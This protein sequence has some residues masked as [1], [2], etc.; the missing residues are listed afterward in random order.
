MF[1]K[2]IKNIKKSFVRKPEEKFKYNLQEVTKLYRLATIDTKTNLF[3]SRYFETQMK[4]EVAIAKRYNRA[5]SLIL[6][7]IDDFKKIN[8]KYGY[9]MGDEILKRVSLILKNNVRDTDIAARFGGEEFTILLPE[10]E[11]DKAKELAER[12]RTIILNDPFLKSYGLTVS[13]GISCEETKRKKQENITKKL[14]SKF[15]PVNTTSLDFFDRANVALKYAKNHGKNQS[16]IF[17][18]SMSF[19]NVASFRRNR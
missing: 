13:I 1:K 17:N 19:S 16:I 6:I 12:I 14:Y 7:D 18:P 11:V 5:I 15:M 10:T 2:I 8:D 4:H 9:K 3:N